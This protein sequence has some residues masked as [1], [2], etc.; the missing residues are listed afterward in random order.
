MNQQVLE[1]IQEKNLAIYG[2]SRSGNKFGN[3]I[4]NELKQRGYQVSVIHPQADEING[5]KCYHSIQ[6]IKDRVNAVLIC[7][8]PTKAAEAIREAAQAGIRKIWLQQG[9]NG[10]ET[11]QA[12]QEM[13][14]SPITGKCI[15]MYAEP[16]T[17]YHRWHRGFAK[18]FG[19]Y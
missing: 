7:L 1:F 2:V 10:M 19:A 18:L 15:L 16:V 11:A 5:E 6:E 3:T 13:Q 14:V 9:A 4:A 17:A 8:P 12:A